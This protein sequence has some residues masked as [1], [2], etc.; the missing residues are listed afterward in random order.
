MR[1]EDYLQEHAQQKPEHCAIVQG[2]EQV[3]YSQLWK[4]IQDCAEQLRANGLEMHRPFVFR[5]SQ[6]ASFVATYCAVHLLN[7]IAVPLEHS[8]SD[9]IFNKVKNEVEACQYPADITDILY[10]TGTSGQAKGV[11][12]SQTCLS[13]CAD[14]F[15]SEMKFHPE[16]AFIVSGPLNHIAS[17]FKIHPILTVGGTLCILDGLRDMNAFF[18]VFELPFQHFATFL[19]PASIRM[20]LQFSSDQLHTVAP[21]IDFIETGAAPI[22]SADMKQLSELLP[23]SRLY[24]TYG[25][26]EI[27]CVSTYQFN[28]GKYMEGCIG[29]TM[30]NGGAMI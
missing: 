13:A 10:T 1:L 22:F 18:Q 24:N 20:L 7:A 8:V 30:P 17:L 28:D 4:D 6:D 29:H 27:G 12:L 14:N 9:E 16:L 5:A 26:T 23:N 11:M 2:S 25:G 15:I 19:V 21:L 3:T